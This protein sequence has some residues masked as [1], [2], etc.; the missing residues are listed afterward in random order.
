MNPLY[1][2]A[3]ALFVLPLCG[4]II[5]EPI[6][7]IHDLWTAK[8]FLA[9]MAIMAIIFASY[10]RGSVHRPAVNYPL[11]AMM[12]YLPISTY[13]APPILLQYGHENMGN[14]WIWR[15]LAWCFAYFLLYQ[16][17]CANPPVMKRHKQAI[18][19]AIGWA[20]IVSAGYAYLQA[21][22]VDQWQIARPYD[23]IGQPA[24]VNITA[25]IGNPTYLSI[26]LGMCLPFIIIF[27]KWPVW[28]FIG[29]AILL[30][31]SDIGTVGSVLTFGFLIC[32]KMDKINFDKPIR[33]DII[34]V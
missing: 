10:S 14:F 23:E 28:I 1:I 9:I 27:Y 31:Q 8:E 11:L 12:V 22:G 2:L 20:A 5:I 7:A 3:G 32:M 4:P 16:S 25:M 26:F 17:I 21:L 15:S 24:A 33:K 19:M 30:C 13:A 6:V 18:I 34:K 29:G